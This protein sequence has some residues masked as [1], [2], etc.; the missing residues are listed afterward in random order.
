[1]AAPRTVG[2][3]AKEAGGSSGIGLQQDVG[4]EG[5][6]IIAYI[7]D[8]SMFNGL[9][10]VNDEIL[11]INGVKATHAKQASE[12][13]LAAGPEL[14]LIVCPRRRHTHRV[15]Y[16]HLTIINLLSTTGANARPDDPNH[17]GQEEIGP[18]R[19][20]LLPPCSLLALLHEFTQRLRLRLSTVRCFHPKSL[21]RFVPP[22][23]GR[24]PL[25]CLCGGRWRAARVG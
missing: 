14:T 19:C 7:N 15:R 18:P 8:D 23:C 22:E 4:R 1:M 11:E 3:I 12:A 17:H 9:L 21:V 13:I 24:A 16:V 10:K 6:C 5:H 2:P 25:H 20:L